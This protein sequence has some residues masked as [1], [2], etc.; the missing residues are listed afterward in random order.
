MAVSL[1][2]ARSDNA[3]LPVPNGSISPVGCNVPDHQQAAMCGIA[4]Y[5]MHQQ[6]IDHGRL[7]DDE[8][9][10]VEGVPAIPPQPPG[11]VGGIVGRGVVWGW[12][13][14]IGFVAFGWVGMAC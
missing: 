2:S 13:V 1:R 7:V 10:A 3:S 9:V 11:C 12:S 14:G 4:E 5:R 8:R 6:N